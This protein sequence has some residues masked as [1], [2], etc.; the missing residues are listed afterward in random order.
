MPAE[1]LASTTC[2]A[3]PRLVLV[4]GFTQTGRSWDALAGSLAADHEV[5]AVD[6]PG[7]GG[8]AAVRAGLVDGAGLLGAAG[9]RATY[10]GYSMGGRLCL[11]LAITRPD[12]V[13]RLVL[14]SATA[15]IDGADERA[16]RRAADDALA[17]ALEHDGLDAFLTRWLAQPMFASLGD[18]GLD[19]RRRNT[20][21]GLAASL[22]QAGTGTQEPL[23]DRLPE[24]PMPVLLV[25]GALDA[26]F[27][28]A[29]ERMAA[30][31][32]DATLAI[33]EG[34]G[35]TVHLERPA[36]FEDVLRGWLRR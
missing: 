23:W 19:D 12:L 30:L 35:H 5:V 7:H 24:L 31:V 26:K 4:H 22:R 3:G 33:V 20:V 15:G 13:E 10:V 25:A 1:Q 14:V 16:T 36:A 11:H 17:G 6:A 32:P 18:A 8:S 34:A 9:G 28:A 29:A 2:G 27:V 21:A